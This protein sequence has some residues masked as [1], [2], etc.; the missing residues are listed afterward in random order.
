MKYHTGLLVK[1]M[2]HQNVPNLPIFGK[3]TIT[4]N[5]YHLIIGVLYL[6]M[7][8]DNFHEIR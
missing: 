5:Y 1:F 2:E 3:P 6:Q 7:M 4:K 8:A